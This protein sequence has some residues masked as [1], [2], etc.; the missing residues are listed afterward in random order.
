[1]DLGIRDR[2]AVVTG[3]DS[4]M[5][6]ATAEI[7]LAEGVK[8]ILTDLPGTPLDKAGVSLK[9]LGDVVVVAADLTKTAQ[10]AALKQAAQDSFGLPDILVHAAGITGPTGPFHELTDE[11]WLKALQSDL[12]TAGRVCR[13]FIPS[14]AETGWGRVVLFGSEDAQQPYTEELP[15]CASK[16][17]I[18]N[19]SKGLSKSYS[20]Q[21]VLVN[22]V[23]PAVIATPMTDEMMTQRAEKE[24]TTFD[25]ALS[26]FLR[27]ER[28]TLELQRRGTA[29]EVAAA[30]AFLCSSH[31]SFINGVNLRIDGGS[32]AT[33]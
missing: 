12:L 25:E 5:G 22:A 13:T 27:Q 23:S 21:G 26:S 8:V 1:M 17:A 33:V 18:L 16:A 32:V 9:R 2:V 29:G 10:V 7:L 3:G 4:G 6:Y 28:P 31:A 15:Y 30:V 19:L 24:G 11:D 14:M 20:R